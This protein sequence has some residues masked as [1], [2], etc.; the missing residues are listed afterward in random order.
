MPRTVLRF[1][2]CL[3]TVLHDRYSYTID[4]FGITEIRVQIPALPLTNTWSWTDL[5]ILSIAVLQF[6]PQTWWLKSTHIYDLTVSMR[7]ESRHGLAGS[8]VSRFLMRLQS[9]V[10]QAWFLSESLTGKDSLTSSHSYWQDLVSC[11]LFDRGSYFL[12][13]RGCLQFL[14]TWVSP[15]WLLSSSKHENWK[16]NRESLLARWKLQSYII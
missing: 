13:T 14:A 4:G 11:S 15:T 3:T 16:G 9:S 8:S 2:M 12:L 5:T 1:Y 6:Y 10:N 7:Q